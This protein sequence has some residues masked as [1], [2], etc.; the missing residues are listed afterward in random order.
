MRLRQQA[1][2]CEFVDKDEQIKGQ[3]IDGYSDKLLC[4]RILEK[5]EAI[6]SCH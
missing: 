5:G 1:A 4:R 2:K 6:L 3:F